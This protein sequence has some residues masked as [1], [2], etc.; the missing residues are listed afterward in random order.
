MIA[1]IE[2]MLKNYPLTHVSP[3]AND[4]E[5]ITPS[6]LQYSRQIVSLPHYDVQDDKQ[7]DHM[8]R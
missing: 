1:E 6:H 2:R 3:D 4:I 8:E 7:S 5:A